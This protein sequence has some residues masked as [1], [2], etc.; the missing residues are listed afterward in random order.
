[1]VK[2]GQTIVAERERVQ[3]AS[4]RMQAR[5]Q[6]KR[7]RQFRLGVAI[8][9]VA[10]VVA[11][12]AVGWQ[13]LAESQQAAVK[14][15]KLAEPQAEIVDESG[16]GQ[17]P[18]RVK[19]YAALLEQD[20]KEAGYTVTRVTLPSGMMRALYIDLE[21]RTEYYKVNTDRGAAVTAEDIQRMVVYLDE[22]DLHPEYVDVRVEGKGYYK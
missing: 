11:L 12:I 2:R 10:V 9:L 8:A 13:K 16:S 17:I 14:E 15:V 3:S 6:Q 22:H 5:Q 21:G 18:T 19:E 20:L 7:K 1:M 4:E